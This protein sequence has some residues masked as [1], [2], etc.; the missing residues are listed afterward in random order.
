[1]MKYLC[2]YA[3]TLVVMVAIDLVWLGIVARPLYQQGIG[4]LMAEQANLT[5]A[6]IFYLVYVSFLVYLGVAPTAGEPGVKPAFI[7][8]ALLGLFAYATYDLTNLAV[9]RGWPIGL[10]LIDMA[11][12]TLISGVA[13]AA[14][15]FALDRFVAS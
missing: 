3:A 15:K 9:L 11:W 7:A 10:A 12:G 6:A 2:A 4:H 5:A 14:G 13:T 1:M 8:G